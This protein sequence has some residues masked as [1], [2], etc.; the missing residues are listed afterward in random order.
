[1]AGMICSDVPKQSAILFI[2]YYFSD[3]FNLDFSKVRKT[4]SKQYKNLAFLDLLKED[5][6]QFVV[7]NNIPSIS[8]KLSLGRVLREQFQLLRPDIHDL[9]VAEA[10]KKC[11]PELRKHRRSISSLIEL[12]LFLQLYGSNS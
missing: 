11:P 6:Y 10:E 4:R 9:I 8:N 5:Y 12:A 1:M 3:N 2:K 7:E